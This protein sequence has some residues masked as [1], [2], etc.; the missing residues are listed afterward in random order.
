MEFF[1]SLLSFILTNLHIP[2]LILL[3][4]AVI[5]L[6]VEINKQKKDIENL[7]KKVKQLESNN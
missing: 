2:A 6:S 1:R 5:I 4:V 3:S 7:H